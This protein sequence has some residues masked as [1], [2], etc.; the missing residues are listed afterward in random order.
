MEKRSFP[1]IKGEISVAYKIMGSSDDG[2]V[3]TMDI[4]G[5][6][7]RLPMYEKVKPETL[8]ELN[9]SL[10]SQEAPFYGLA[11]V[12]WQSRTAVKGKG[13]KNYFETGIK[14][15]RVGL[16]NRKQIVRYINSLIKEGNN[17][18]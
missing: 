13:G 12:I 15:I 7:F 2:E 4:S 6:G 18:D 9:I 5:G 14:F 3:R 10:P 17:N 8:V 16:N 11:K 1:R